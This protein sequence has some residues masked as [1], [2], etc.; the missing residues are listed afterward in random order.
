MRPLAIYL[1]AVLALGDGLVLLV[2]DAV[3]AVAGASTGVP[4]AAGAEGEDLRSNLGLLESLTREAVAELADSLDLEGARR[5]TVLSSTWHE[6][7]AF[8]AGFLGRRLAERGLEV[9]IIPSA[10]SADSL[11]AGAAPSEPEP[12]PGRIRP[13]RP[14][15]TVPVGTAGG[16][17]EAG[18]LGDTTGAYQDSIDAYAQNFDPLW[19]Q[20]I[21][22]S[23]V[24]TGQ[25]SAPAQPGAA[26]ASAG[27]ESA[28]AASTPK[29]PE[30]DVLDLRIMEFGVGYSEFSR[31]LLFGPVR[32]SR[33]AGVYLQVS[34]LE[35]PDGV[36]KKVVTAERHWVQRLT[37]A[38]RYL[39]EGAAFPFKAPEMQKP[40]L[41]RYIEP[42]VVVAIAG[43]LVFLFYKNQD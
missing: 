36:L 3:F 23:L 10:P 20:L 17:G 35:G 43:M 27:G 2:S 40:S 5:V 12:G 34:H 22:S 32:F 39:A 8:V 42:A 18:A 21:D 41:G 11:T 1:A 9:V 31:S 6:G 38:Q 13:G 30:G 33:I 16:A 37:G 15:G 7:N 19:G 14:G 26:A 25:P 24:T 29:L 4:V 28:K